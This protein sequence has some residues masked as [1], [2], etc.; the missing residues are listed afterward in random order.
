MRSQELAHA[1]ALE[2]EIRA[3][4][5]AA[6]DPAAARDSV[7]RVVNERVRRS[8]PDDIGIEAFSEG[9]VHGE[10]VI[11][12]LDPETR[13]AIFVH[14]GA[15]TLGSAE[16][17]RELA[18]RIARAAQARLLVL[19]YRLA[20]EHPHP[21]ARD[22]VVAAFRWLVADGADHREIALVG[23]STGAAL[24]LAAAQTLRDDGDPPPGTIALMSPVVDLALG[25]EAPTAEDPTRSWQ[26][27]KDGVRA[28][29]GTTSPE[30][31]A[32]SPV[33]ADLAGLPSLLILLGTA[34]P[35]LTQGRDLIQRARDA[36]VEVT[37]R[38]YA[39]MPHRWAIY[40]HIYEAVQASNQLGEY[41]LQRLGPGYVP[42]Q[43][44]ATA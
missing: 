19:D 20:P 39:E 26:S 15:G 38:E 10:W 33:R 23:E 7:G 43:G 40:P 11:P 44:L 36:G 14:G 32:V 34:D 28:A 5:A 21:A 37:D 24:V 8:V 12:P 29:L 1:V 30:D 22:D 4:V 2:E 41:L 13:V 16:E 35:F 9:A 27:V 31:P 6:P 42:V 25:A 18:A 3:L 17:S